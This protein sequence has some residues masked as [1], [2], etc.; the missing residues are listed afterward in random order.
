MTEYSGVVGR[1]YVTMRKGVANNTII[2]KLLDKFYMTHHSLGTLKTTMT[3]CRYK[4]YQSVFHCISVEFIYFC[5]NQVS[6]GTANTRTTYQND[7]HVN[8]RNTRQVPNANVA[9]AYTLS[10]KF[11]VNLRNSILCQSNW[12]KIS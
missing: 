1:P 12:L 6:Y 4:A 9:Q 7:R 5:R 8:L 10:I 2:R 11:E 3:R